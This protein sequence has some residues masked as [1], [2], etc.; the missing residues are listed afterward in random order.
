MDAV[1]LQFVYHFFRDERI[2]NHADSLGVEVPNHLSDYWDHVDSPGLVGVDDDRVRVHLGDQVQD[3]LTVGLEWCPRLPEHSEFWPV[4]IPQEGETRADSGSCRYNH[5]ALE[6]P[7][8]VCK[9]VYQNPSLPEMGG[10]VLDAGCRPVPCFG[11]QCREA[12]TFWVWERGKAMPV[13]QWVSR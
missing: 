12:F 8:C 5:H 4:R 1:R 7:H 13:L 6:D 9:A 11:D 3:I 2:A 10:W